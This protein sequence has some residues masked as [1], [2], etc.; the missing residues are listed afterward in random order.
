MDISVEAE[1]F[2]AKVRFTEDEVSAI[3]VQLISDED[4]ANALEVPELTA[5]RTLLYLEAVRTAKQST[6]DKPVIAGM[7]GPYSLAGCL[8]DVAE[9]MHLC[10]D[11]PE[12][13]HTVLGRVTSTSSPTARLRMR[14][15][16]MTS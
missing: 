9:V 4:E 7:I 11:E 10:Y 2:G 14:R 15:A 16:L 6:T 1:T 13:V 5:G 8:C 3:V 12:T